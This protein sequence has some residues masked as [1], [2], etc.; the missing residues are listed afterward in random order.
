MQRYSPC[1]D[2]VDVEL[3]ERDTFQD[4]IVHSSYVRA[5]RPFSR[6]GSSTSS[7]TSSSAIR[8]RVVATDPLR[9]FLHLNVHGAVVSV[10]AVRDNAMSTAAGHMLQ[11]SSLT[12]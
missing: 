12:G 8:W 11:L 9:G 10:G 5:H 2:A 6:R 7:P 4:E 3:F 1:I